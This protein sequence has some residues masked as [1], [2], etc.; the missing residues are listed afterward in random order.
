MP[1]SNVIDEVK[2]LQNQIKLHLETQKSD[3]E[4]FKA[5]LLEKS[6]QEAKGTVDTLLTNKIGNATEGIIK[7]MASMQSAQQKIEAALKRPQSDFGVKGSDAAA[8]HYFKQANGRN[9]GRDAS[10]DSAESYSAFKNT[11][12]EQFLKK[13]KDERSFSPQ[14]MKDL[15]VGSDPDGGYT[16]PSELANRITE[17]ARETSPWRQLCNVETTSLNEWE[18][19]QDPNDFASASVNETE[20]RSNTTTPELELLRIPLHEVYANP[21]ITQRLLDDSMLDMEAWLTRRVADKITRTENQLVATGTG[22]DEAKGLLTYTAGTTWGTVEQIDSG[23]N[24]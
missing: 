18:I 15:S 10:G 1:D 2:G 24:G 17:V 6:K 14:E 23:A 20:T 7:Q 9:K 3:F 22:L 21:R 16:A 13:G 4:G 19:V 11:Y 5:D 12:Y 8:Q